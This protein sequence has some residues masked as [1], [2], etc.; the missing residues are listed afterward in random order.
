MRLVGLTGGIGSGKS[1]VS[2]MLAERGAVILDADRFAREAVARG[3][4]ALG[5]IVQRFGPDVL[6]P[7]GDL[8][9][10]AL[11]KI[12]FADPHAR[13]GLEAI[14]HPEVRRRIAEGIQ[15]NLDTD[16]VVVLVNP[17]LIE[18]G[19]HRDCELVVVMSV[20]PATQVARSLAR[21]MQ[22]DDVRARIAAQ[23]PLD[24][25]ARHADVLL[26]NEGSVQDLE[27]QVD[28][29]WVRLAQG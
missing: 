1:T 14:V 24:E 18:M 26:D 8:D 21:G 20:D 11:A 25:R 22:E 3:S 13:E 27:A 12:V 16:R 28:A 7:E 29:L 5:R 23:M 9:R 2:A 4:D 15:A 17:L 6:T 10:Q 19:T